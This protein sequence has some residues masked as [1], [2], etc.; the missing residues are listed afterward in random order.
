MFSKF[1]IITNRRLDRLTEQTATQSLITLRIRDISPSVLIFGVANYNF[2]SK[3]ARLPKQNASKLLRIRRA[4]LQNFIPI[5]EVSSFREIK[6]NYKFQTITVNFKTDN[7]V[8][9][10]FFRN[11]DY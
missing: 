2:Y 6:K 8:E 4:H 5:F 3:I 9:I 11:R 10:I 1:K 7:V